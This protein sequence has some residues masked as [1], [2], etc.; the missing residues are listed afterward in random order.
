MRL[1]VRLLFNLGSHAP[2]GQGHFWQDVA[3]GT[4]LAALLAAWGI[5]PQPGK[6][7]LLNGRQ[8]SLDHVPQDGDVLVVFPPVEGG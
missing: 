2:G 5:P 7:L 4:T 1:E 8:A 3:P 6:V